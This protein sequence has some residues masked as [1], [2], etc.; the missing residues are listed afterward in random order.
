M[1][2]V[3]PNDQPRLGIFWVAEIRPGEL[4]LLAEGC[5]LEAAEPY[6]DCLT[7]GP[8]HYETWEDWRRKRNQ[9]PAIRALV[10]EYEYEDWPRGRIV[11]DKSNDRFV[12]YADRQ[13]MTPGIIAAIRERFRL[14]AERTTVETDLHYRSRERL[15]A[16]GESVEIVQ[17]FPLPRYL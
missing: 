7:F 8:G 16:D 10:R 2:G 12:L 11:L 3:H 13:L 4:H 6:G 1:T 14:P 15:H 5:D 9:D 17:S